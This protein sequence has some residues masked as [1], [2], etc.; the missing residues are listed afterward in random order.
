M[1]ALWKTREDEFLTSLHCL[2]KVRS[3]T[4][5]FCRPSALCSRLWLQWSRSSTAFIDLVW[6]V[7]SLVRWPIC[8]PNYY[9]RRVTAN[10]VPILILYQSLI[11]I[12]LLFCRKDSSGSCLCSSNQVDILKTGWSA[13]CADVHRWRCEISSRRVCFGQRKG[14]GYH[15]HRWVGRNW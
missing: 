15:F 7:Q 13:T 2:T 11:I 5:T 6:S 9:L 14:A 4:A 10:Q 1:M 12:C 8:T 3:L